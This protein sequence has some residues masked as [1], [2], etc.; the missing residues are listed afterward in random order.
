M[1]LLTAATAQLAT[2]RL[3]ETLGTFVGAVVMTLTALL[4]A[5][6]PRR[7]PAYVLDLGAFY[8]LTPAR[9]ACV[10]SR[11]GSVAIRSRAFK[12]SA[13]CSRSSS[14]CSWRPRRWP[15]GMPDQS[16]SF[17]VELS[18]ALDQAGEAV[19]LNQRRVERIAAA[20][21]VQDA[22]VAV[23]P[24]LV[25]AGEDSSG[26]TRSRRCPTACAVGV[27]AGHAVL[28]VGLAL[29]LQPT[30]TSLALTTVFGP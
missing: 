16:V 26:W 6:S 13:T 5:R 30:P 14:A 18:A 15:R 3:G 10:A 9:T 22:H 19:S 8:V 2:R 23:L 20:Y 1:I 25:I 4:L 28:T 11:A 21:G 7:P 27:I 29:I 24:N 17:I 12:G